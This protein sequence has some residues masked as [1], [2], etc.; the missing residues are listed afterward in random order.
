MVAK[1]TQVLQRSPVAFCKQP[2]RPIIQ[3]ALVE[4][5][6]DDVS[7]ADGL[8]D[9]VVDDLRVDDGVI[10]S[11]ALVV[12]EAQLSPFLLGCVVYVLLGLALPDRKRQTG[13]QHD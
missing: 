8:L 12:D 10:A 7:L 6:S 5:E 11:V 2:Y 13:T 4:V 3:V 9:E 1:E